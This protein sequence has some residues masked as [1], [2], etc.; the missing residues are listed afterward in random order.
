[1]SLQ[2]Q[3]CESLAK[4]VFDTKINFNCLSTTEIETSLQK[5]CIVRKFPLGI[6]AAKNSQFLSG[7]LH[8]FFLFFL[9]VTFR[10]ATLKS[11]QKPNFHWGNTRVSTGSAPKFVKNCT[12]INVKIVLILA[13]YITIDF[14]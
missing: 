8:H 9:M 1:M 2:K 11:F 5:N 14:V 4:K 7:I 6:R 10:F 3:F 12:G 13:K